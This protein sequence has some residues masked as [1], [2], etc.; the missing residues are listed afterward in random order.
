VADAGLLLWAPQAWLGGHWRDAVLL[1]ATADGRWAEVRPDTPPPADAQRLAGP[2]VPG[3][4][5][6]H[7]H[8]FQRAFAG[9]AERRTSAS[10]DFWS[11][12]DRM[13]RVALRIGPDQLEAVAAQLYAELLRGGYTQVCEF[14]YLHHDRDGARYADPLTMS[15]A[16]VRA[17]TR[18]GIGLTLLPVLYQRAGFAQ[19][20]LRDDQRRFASDVDDVVR[21]RDAARAQ[22]AQRV[23]AGVAIHSLRAASAGSIAALAEACRGDDGPIHIHIAEQTGE[24]DDCLAATGERPIQWLAQHAPIDAR[25]QLVHATHATPDEIDAV[26]RSGAGV[27]ICPSTEANLG[28]GVPDLPRWLAAGVPLSVGSDSQVTRAWREELRQLEYA[29]RL[30]LRRR[31]VAAA[32]QDG[33]DSTAQRL[34]DAALAGGARAA[35]FTQWGLDAGAPADLLVIDRDDACLLGLPTSHWLDALV[36]SSPARPWRD[37]LCGGRWVVRE[38]RHAAGEAI[39]RDFVTAMTALEGDS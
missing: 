24:V 14:H 3:L 18:A 32:P 9:L 38:H 21:W 17:A 16:L 10:D 29:Q 27:V 31:N 13:Y 12:R 39:A 11:W 26:A 6:A 35:G 28:D 4:V 33:V 23:L 25:W 20:A 5:N 30:T 7:S 15:Q 1:R 19:A 22:R 2:V 36:F 8:A 34:F 37:V